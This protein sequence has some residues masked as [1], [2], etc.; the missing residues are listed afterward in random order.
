MSLKHAL[1]ILLSRFSIIFKMILYFMV[2][3]LIFS[4]IAGSVF[5]PTIRAIS[6]DI[7]DTGIVAD[8][9]EGLTKLT[10]GDPTFTESFERASASLD[11]VADIITNNRS[12]FMWSI[13][14]VI[15]FFVLAAYVLSLSYISYSD[16]INHFMSSNSRFGFISNFIANLKRSLLY[17]LMHLL[18]VTL[19]NWLI[20]Y[21][22]MFLTGVLLKSIGIFSAP[23]IITLGIVLYSLKSTVF[24]GWLPAIVHENKKVLPAFVHGIK[25]ISE[26]GSQAFLSF[27]MMYTLAFVTIVLFSF[28]TFGAGLIL[29][30]PT[31]MMFHRALEL[32][33]YYN[34][35]DY[36]YYVDNERVIKKSI[37]K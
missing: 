29:I 5:A 4:T 8:F 37:Y 20:A 30:I 19:S 28:T 18:T 27:I 32:V 3:V 23:I 24:A 21:F 17:G 10:Q 9:K 34:A 13:I 14:I 33:L 2:V 35:N 31:A 26:R 7:A 12:K 16:I 25:T 6:N 1:S 15:L 11:Q 36:K 22:L